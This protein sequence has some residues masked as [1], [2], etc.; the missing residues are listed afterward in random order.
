MWCLINKTDIHPPGEDAMKTLIGI[1]LAI[2]LI[3][4]A[5]NPLMHQ[6]IVYYDAGV[7]GE[8][9]EYQYSY[10]MTKPIESDSFRYTKN[11]LHFDLY[12]TSK[13][14]GFSIQNK[15]DHA[16]EV[17]WD[18]CAM[19]VDANSDKV[20]HTG[21][22]YAESGISQPPSVIP[23][24]SKLTDEIYPISYVSDGHPLRAFF[25]RPVDWGNYDIFLTHD[26]N[27]DS[28]K[29]AIPKNV[30]RKLG[31]LFTLKDEKG[32]DSYYFEFEITKVVPK[33][34]VVVEP[35]SSIPQSQWR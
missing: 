11:D 13:S 1:L 22:K 8:G 7:N 20:F 28:L 30:G 26:A 4:C 32:E 12:I 9:A 19:V 16:I 27:D 2:S 24:M 33:S 18:K 23:P 17:V 6:A 10:K 34:P 31:A 21:V 29:Q 25:G 15:S 3:G 35:K 14:V 5:S